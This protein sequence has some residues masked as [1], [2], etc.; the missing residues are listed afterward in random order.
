MLAYCHIRHQI[1]YFPIKR[2]GETSFFLMFSS[3]GLLASHFGVI[4]S[5]FL[6]RIS[7]SIDGGRKDVILRGDFQAD[8]E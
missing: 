4:C 5:K 1:T 8:H 7:R 2:L 3:L 6:E